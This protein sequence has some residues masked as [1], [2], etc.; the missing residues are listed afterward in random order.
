M[1]VLFIK[2]DTAEIMLEGKVMGHILDV[3]GAK[4]SY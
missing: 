2:T 3:L 1:A 4:V